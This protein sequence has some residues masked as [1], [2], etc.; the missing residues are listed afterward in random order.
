MKTFLMANI[1]A[2]L[3]TASAAEAA[4]HYQYRVAFMPDIH[5]HDVYGTFQDGAFSGLKNQ[6]SGQN[7]MIRTMYA[8]LTSTRLFNENYFALRAAL[9]DAGSKGIKLIALPGDFSD[10]GQP[11][12][13][14]GLVTL[15]QEYQQKYGMRFFATPGNHDPNRPFDLPGGEEDFLGAGGKTQRIFSFGAKECKGYQGKTAVIATGAELPTIC[16]QEM[17]SS[18]Y[19]YIM[20]MMAPFGMNPQQTDIY[21]ETPYSSYDQQHYSYA[22]A[23]Q[24]S[25]FRQ[26]QYEICAQGTGGKYKKPGYGPCFTVADSSY[27][28]EPVPGLWLMAVDANVYLPTKNADPTKLTEASNFEGSGDAGYNKMLTHKQQTVAWMTDVAQRAKAQ[29]KT[30][31]T[32]SH[33]PMVEFDNGAAGDLENI[34]GKGKFQLARAPQEDTSHALAKTGIGVHVGGH[35]H[36]ND[37]GVRKYPD[38]SLLFNIQAPSMAAYVP[39]YKILNFSSPNSIDVQTI[40][41]NSVPRFNELFEHYQQEWDHL[42]AIH[43]PHLWNKAVLGARDY[44]D[45]TNWHIT[46]LTRL[47][48]IPEEWPCEIRQMLFSLN[49]AEMLTLSQLNSPLAYQEV[50]TT[51][52]DAHAICAKGSAPAPRDISGLYLKKESAAWREAESRARTLAR[53]AGM[54]LEEF[55]GWNGF[56]LAVDFY[57]LRNADELALRDISVSRLREYRLLTLT[58]AKSLPAEMPEVT[59]DSPFDMIFRLRFGS[60]F[61]V[62][63]KYLKGSPSRNF[64]LDTKTGE[65]HAI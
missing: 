30:L 7:A 17:V 10:D 65:I 41:L 59:A 38:G 60:I 45:F 33:F 29:N 5:F 3:L 21:W 31:I 37:T 2:L 54:T 4:E 20:N 40:I 14:R 46:E 35:M 26:R 36:F 43:S 23:Q 50:L 27:L 25:D 9:D 8:Q 22:K 63:D 62:I 6:K 15:L 55:A 57:R 51:P 18:G 52:Q 13:I 32:F 39:A 64:H 49:G 48:F 53:N 11:V 19:Q 16:S 56:D 42:N 47:R 28:V 34:F 1:A 58:L 12:H 44:Y 61:S 24:A